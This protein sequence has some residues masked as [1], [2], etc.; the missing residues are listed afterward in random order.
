MSG[1]TPYYF[2]KKEEE[3][4]KENRV[5]R[6]KDRWMSKPV[7]AIYSDIKPIF[8]I[9]VFRYLQSQNLQTVP[10]FTGL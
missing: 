10:E 5:T 9:S 6:P 2:R 8:E 7:N 1:K 4:D 3:L